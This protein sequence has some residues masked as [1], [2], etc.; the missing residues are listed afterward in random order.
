MAM[1]SLFSN[2]SSDKYRQS[3]NTLLPTSNNLLA[4]GRVVH[5]VKLITT[6]PAHPIGI[7]WNRTLTDDL[8]YSKTNGLYGTSRDAPARWFIQKGFIV[9]SREENFHWYQIIFKNTNQET[10]LP[11]TEQREYQQNCFSIE[12]AIDLHSR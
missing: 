2:H 7:I 8:S 6:I 9:R 12:I 1:N 10:Y 4:K 3:R 5:I 11:N